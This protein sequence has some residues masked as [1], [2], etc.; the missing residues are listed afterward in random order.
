MNLLEQ[1]RDKI[2]SSDWIIQ[3]E[4][5]EEEEREEDERRQISK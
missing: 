3:D 5:D 1:I 4:Q 2:I